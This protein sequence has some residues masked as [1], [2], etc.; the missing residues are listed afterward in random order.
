MS[1]LLIKFADRVLNKLVQA[2]GRAQA[3][4]VKRQL[5]HRKLE[6]L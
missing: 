4:W 1:Y 6:E 5:K 3:R 2:N